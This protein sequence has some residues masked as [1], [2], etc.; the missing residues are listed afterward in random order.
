MKFCGTKEENFST[1]RGIYGE[2]LDVTG[3]ERVFDFYD[4]LANFDK[5]A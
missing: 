5:K 1:P 3:L 4:F 2:L